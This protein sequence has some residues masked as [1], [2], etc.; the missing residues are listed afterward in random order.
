MEKFDEFQNK[1]FNRNFGPQDGPLCCFC[2]PMRIGVIL[3]FL[4]LVMDTFETV[5][6]S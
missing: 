1:M 6:M 3:M 4:Y 5:M 2:I